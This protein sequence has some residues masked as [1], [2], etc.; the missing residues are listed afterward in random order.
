MSSFPTV[1]VYEYFTGGGFPPGELPAGL[2][3]EALGMLWA[4]LEDFRNWGKV[5]TIA[6][7]DPR[8]EDRIPGLNRNNLPANE[9]VCASPGDHIE[10]YL[11]LLQHCNA[12]LIIAPETDG[13]LAELTER[14]EKAGTPLLC[15]SSSAAATAGD[16]A[17]CDLLFRQAK[18]STPTT[19]IASFDE[20]SILAG[21]LGFPLIIKPLDGVGSEGVLRINSPSSLL[22]ALPKIRRVTSHKQILLQSYVKG[23]H[24]SV[25]LL[26]MN[27]RVLPLSLNRQLI[28]TGQHLQYQGSHIPFHHKAEDQAFELACS[29]ARLIPGLRGYVGV[30]LVL[31]NDSPQ[32]IEINP[33]LTTS[34]IGLRQVAQRNL[35]QL[36]WDACMNGV[37]PD[38]VPLSGSVTIKKDDPS[39]WGLHSSS[40][41]N[42]K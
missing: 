10:L 36:I 34:Y 33:R 42:E 26:V 21:Q 6:A 24:A 28:V 30:D 19:L 3:A 31:A 1:L 39:S 17:V 18:L 9:V 5:R 37:F 41:A 23:I 29:A 15:S 27:G 25:S 8:F 40:T 38:S 16:K 35:A 22:K 13:V 32:L 20:A 11:S 4:L 14:A 7:L 12:V 2:A